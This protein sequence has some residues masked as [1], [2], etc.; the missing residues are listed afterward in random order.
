MRNDKVALS[1]FD[2]SVNAGRYGIKKAQEAVNKVYGKKCC[3]CGWS[4]WTSDAKIFE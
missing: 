1:I 4:N 2:F 3:E